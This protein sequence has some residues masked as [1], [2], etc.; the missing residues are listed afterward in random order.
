M[1]IFFRKVFIVVFGT[2]KN[3]ITGNWRKVLYEML[4][5]LHS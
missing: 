4:H 2:N 1:R 5:Y 3:E